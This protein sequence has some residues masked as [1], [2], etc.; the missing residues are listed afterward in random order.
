MGWVLGA[1]IM[2]VSLAHLVFM[3]KSGKYMDSSCRLKDKSEGASVYWMVFL[4]T[5]AG[6]LLG[7]SMLAYALR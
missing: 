5:V 1:A 3:L 6:L 7:I 4:I 2:L